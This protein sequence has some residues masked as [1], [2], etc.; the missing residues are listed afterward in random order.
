MGVRQSG[1]MRVLF[2]CTGNICRSPMAEALLRHALQERGCS[3]VEVVSAGTWADDGEPAQPQVTE[4]LS[5][6][7]V[8]LAD[9]KA[10]VLTKKETASSDLVIAMTSVH[11]KEI[12]KVDPD[13]EGKLFLMKELIEIQ[14]P[15]PGSVRSKSRLE[16]LLDSR[17]PR[18][19]RA[20]DVDDP[21]G[22][23][24]SAYERTL[25]DLRAGVEVLA[26][27]LCE[28][29]KRGSSTQPE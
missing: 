7:G 10:R 4:V 28:R 18:W 22:L 1:A 5:G 27:V 21:M 13:A 29:E 14:L 24:V 2:V 17:R 11:M 8:E 9:H 23:P 6:A 15:S 3:D 19:R 16:Q 25:G 12:L 26:E 20:L